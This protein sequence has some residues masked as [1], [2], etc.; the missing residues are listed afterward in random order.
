M[1]MKSY[2]RRAL[3]VALA[4]A[5][6]TP[7][8]ATP[9]APDVRVGDGMALLLENGEV[10]RNS[11]PRTTAVTVGE[12][13]TL[14][15]EGVRIVN[16]GAGVRGQRSYGVL[17]SHG[18]DVSLL[19]S[20]VDLPGAWGVGLQARRNALLSLRHTRVNL[21]ADSGLGVATTLGSYTVLDDARI[22]S[23]TGGTGLLVSDD[24]SRLAA[25]RSRVVM[26][27]ANATALSIV[28]GTAEIRETVLDAREGHAIDT[29]AGTGGAAR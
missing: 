17:A 16:D 21:A 28:G 20:D 19:D 24:A 23:A 12:R 4:G 11:R 22:H 26:Q 10:V 9:R 2:G 7:A 25:Q 15:A 13:A 6:V 18:A 27:G 8:V 29:R 14:D 5:F 3:A 1:D